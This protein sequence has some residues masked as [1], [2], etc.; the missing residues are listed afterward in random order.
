MYHLGHR[1]IHRNRQFTGN[2]LFLINYCGT[3]ISQY[4]VEGTAVT[5]NT[6][7]VRCEVTAQDFCVEITGLKMDYVQ[8]FRIKVTNEV[9]MA[10]PDQSQIYFISY[11]RE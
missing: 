11:C 5:R 8:Y 1:E 6:R 10:S 4:L 3:K 7:E 2:I 9:E